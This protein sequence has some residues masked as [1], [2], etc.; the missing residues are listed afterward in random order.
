MAIIKNTDRVCISGQTGTGKTTL[1]RHFAS[2]YEDKIYVLDPINQYTQFGEPGDIREGKKRC[3]PLIS[4][5]PQ[6]LEKIARAL[7]YLENRTLVIEEAEQFI[8]QRKPLLPYTASLIQMGRNWGIGIY[9]ITR[10]IQE[11]NKT[12]FDLAQHVFFYRCGF[13]SREY[14]ADMIGKD[15]MYPMY[16]PGQPKLNIT[17]Y[18]I[19]TL[20]RYHCLHFNLET[21]E[22]QV[23]IVN[24]GGAREHL[25]QVTKGQKVKVERRQQ[26]QVDAPERQPEA[27]ERPRE[28][29]EEELWVPKRRR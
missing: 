27:Q 8:P 25:E 5:G 14:I 29:E 6:E 1:A 16:R 24:L 22:A 28:R 4:N 12:F 9:C 23:V 21:E 7:H 20:P 19:T 10:R 13:K 15:F 26:E 11:I 2:I 17:G 3:V 18:T